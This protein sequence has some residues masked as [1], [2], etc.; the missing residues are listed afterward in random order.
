MQ[1][2]ISNLRTNNNSEVI[3]H[4]KAQESNDISI[5][6]EDI[7]VEI[8]SQKVVRLECTVAILEA[9]VSHLSSTISQLEQ[10]TI[11]LEQENGKLLA[12]SLTVNLYI[13]TAKP[14]IKN[15]SLFHT[16]SF[17]I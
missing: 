7:D 10:N 9:E 15:E 6:H 8:E 1:N 13:F 5:D 3:S 16:K 11:N 14:Y 4:E 12:E 2:E 17:I